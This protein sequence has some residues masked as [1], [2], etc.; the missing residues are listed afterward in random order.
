M[1]R[2]APYTILLAGG[3][4]DGPAIQSALL[5][6][7]DADFEL[8][9]IGPREILARGAQVDIRGRPDVVIVGPGLNQ[10]LA[11][12]SQLRQ[13]SPRAQVVFL[14]SGEQLERFRASLPFVPNLSDAW[15]AAVEDPEETTSSVILAAARAARRREEIGSALDRINMQISARP[16]LGETERRDR[17]MRLSERYMATVL[18]QAPDAILAVDLDGVVI[19]SNDAA[20]RL[21]A[22]H[23]GGILGRSVTLFFA[24]SGRKEVETLLDRARAG[25]IVARHESLV[26]SADGSLRDAVIGLAPVRDSEGRI[27]GL[28]MT[29]RDVTELKRA[30]AERKRLDELEGLLQRRQKVETLG[31]M[32]TSIAHEL[33]QPLGSIVTNGNAA[34]RWLARDE[35]DLHEAQLALQRVVNDGHRASQI[36]ASIR[37]MVRRE[38]QERVRL[39]VNELVREVLGLVEEEATKQQVTVQTELASGLPHVL[40]ER[41]QLQQVILNLITNAVEAMASIVGRRRLLRVKSE[42]Q[43]SDGV[44]LTIEDSGIGIDTADLNRIFSPFFTTKPNGMGMGLSI[45]R[46]IVEAHGGRLSASPGKSGG[47]AFQVALPTA[48][49]SAE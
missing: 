40:G 33:N 7:V 23:Q 15:T 46:T 30:E 16:A 45:C 9:E 34:L 17:Q 13:H 14:L 22:S 24:V 10:P 3:V 12:A 29:I 18:M 38:R 42:L 41:V 20:V 43:G 2:P 39:D 48:G 4:P 6:E 8:I 19:S 1:E 27:V 5:R 31:E 21:L 11:A 28:A 37:T 32:A 35:P 26:T 36:I 44:L 47:S 49:A 25:E